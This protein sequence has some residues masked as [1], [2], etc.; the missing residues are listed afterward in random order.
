[1]TIVSCQIVVTTAIERNRRGRKMLECNELL[2]LQKDV[3]QDELLELLTAMEDPQEEEQADDVV[4]HGDDNEGTTT[5][6]LRQRQHVWYD[7]NVRH[8]LFATWLVETFGLSRLASG[9]GVLDVAGGKGELGATLRDDHQIPSILLDPLPRCDRESP[10][11]PIIERPLE[12]DG[13][14]I[15]KEDARIAHLMEHC[16]IL[17]GMHPDQATE[18]IVDTAMRLGKPFAILP[19]CVMP[20]LFPHR[21]Q[22]RHHNQPVRSHPTFC[23]YLL[24]KAPP[25]CTF[26]VHHL[27][28]NGRNKVIYFDFQCPTVLKTT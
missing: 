10:P 24:D 9:T 17:T 16:S 28:F 13:S 6:T 3:D 26:Q 19:C 14:V 4:A 5:T 15:M 18:A 23:Q 25:G 12:G 7:K 2:D 22:K 27:P 20:K 8:R 11:F 21:L 1:M